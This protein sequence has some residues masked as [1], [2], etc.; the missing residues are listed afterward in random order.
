MKTG[1][2]QCKYIELTIFWLKITRKIN[3]TREIH[4][5][6]KVTQQKWKF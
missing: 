3:F 6:L 2:K 1:V 5:I 4:E